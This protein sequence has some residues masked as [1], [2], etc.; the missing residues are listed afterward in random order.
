MVSS[1]TDVGGIKTSSGFFDRGDIQQK[2]VRSRSDGKAQTTL[3]LSGIRCGGCVNKLHRA[4][5][6]L[7]GISEFDINYTTHRARLTWDA[8]LTPLSTI[9]DTI[10]DSGFDA[11]PFVAGSREQSLRAENRRALRRLGIAGLGTMQVMMLAAGGYF[12]GDSMSAEIERLLL[13][14][15]LLVTTVVIAFCGRLF[16]VNAINSLLHRNLGMDVPVTLAIVA[17]YGASLLHVLSAQ[18]ETYFESVCMFIFFLLCGRYLELRARMRAGR[19]IDNLASA[20]PQM[21]RRLD[22]G[23]VNLVTAE[24]L[25]AGDTVLVKPG[26]TVPA[27]GS[28]CSPSA[29]LDESM[30]TGESEPVKHLAGAAV[31]A[32]SINAGNPIELTVRAAGTATRLAAIRHLAEQAETSRPVETPV[33][34][35]I[36]SWFVAAVLIAALLVGGFWTIYDSARVFEVML[37][38]LVVSCPCALSLATPAALTAAIGRLGELGVLLSSSRSLDQLAAAS[39]VLFDKTG[40][41]TEGQPQLS[42]THPFTDLPASECRRIAAALE[43]HVTH[44]IAYAFAEH[45]DPEI[46]ADNLTQVIGAGVSGDIGGV[47]YRLGNYLFSAAADSITRSAQPPSIDAGQSGPGDSQTVV[48]LTTAETVLCRF[49]LNDRLRQGAPKAVSALRAR[50]IHTALLSGDEKN[51]TQ[52]TAT[53]CGIDS[54]TGRL[55]PEGKLEALREF[56]A[57]GST[58]MAGDGINDAAVLAAADFSFAMGQAA[59]LSKTRADAVLLNNELELIPIAID[60]AKRCQR[61]IRQNLTWALLYNLTALPLAASGLLLPWM[62]AL[63]M[64]A[65]SLIV[66]TNAVRLHSFK[67]EMTR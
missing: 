2:F 66:V 13:W 57:S 33:A 54:A 62:A 60:L 52:T 21:A 59:D 5:R 44:P 46:K 3:L 31:Y 32:G 34:D 38:I 19:H 7:T 42:E 35:R 12:A 29:L 27:D 20:V 41:L 17:A 9:L 58:I 49:E 36:A 6:P 18:G 39:H 47:H 23:T 63:G 10:H 14:C 16:I 11:Q 15:S 56:Q 22:H 30:L 65:S 26:E 61:T 1:A 4:V 24:S 55:T 37:A 48:W 64:S 45:D 53:R 50:N 8:S 28:L 25:I 40:T 43:R 67:V 51:I